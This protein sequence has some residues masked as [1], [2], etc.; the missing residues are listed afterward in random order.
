MEKSIERNKSEGRG[1]AWRVAVERS[2]HVKYLL[3]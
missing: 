1:L 3:C 2:V